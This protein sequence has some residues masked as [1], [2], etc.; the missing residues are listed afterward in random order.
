[1][2]SEHS[3]TKAAFFNVLTPVPAWVTHSQDLKICSEHVKLADDRQKKNNAALGGGLS[4]KGAGGANSH[5]TAEEVQSE[6][7][8]KEHQR[9]VIIKTKTREN[10]WK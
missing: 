9:A 2:S 4:R 3:Y 10:L 6:D 7:M 1:M 5:A 8:M